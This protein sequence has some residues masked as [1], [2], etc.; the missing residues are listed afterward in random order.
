[1]GARWGGNGD[2]ERHCGWGSGPV[3]SA[4]RGGAGLAA[5]NTLAAFSAS[6]ALGLRYFETD[7][8]CTRDGVPVLS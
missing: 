6:H 2:G 8:R 5:E 3:A 4:Q 1:M 7:V